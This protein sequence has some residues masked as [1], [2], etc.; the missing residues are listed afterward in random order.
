[1][2]WML[3]VVLLVLG[4]RL[5]GQSPSSTLSSFI[6]ANYQV[7]DSASGDLTGDGIKDLV[8]ILQSATE[9]ANP[10]TTRPLLLLQGSGKGH[11]QLMSRND[12]VVCCA[13]CGGV[14]GDPYAGITIKGKYFS[15][16]HYGGSG[17]RW[18]RVITFKYDPK[19]KHFILHRDAGESF[20]TS[21]P[22]KT[23]QILHAPESFGKTTLEDYSNAE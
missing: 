10:D 19:T 22:D 2:K 15:I 4:S 23:E 12:H 18:T 20:H 6:P 7:L 13:N 5:V 1:M 16:E 11:Y 8:L 17:W 14:F 9:A 21:N 3:S